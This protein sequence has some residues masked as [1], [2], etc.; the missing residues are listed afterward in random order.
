MCDN[1]SCVRNSN[2][3][4]Y[5]A[6]FLKGVKP[7]HHSDCSTCD[8]FACGSCAFAYTESEVNHFELCPSDERYLPEPYSF[9]HDEKQFNF[10]PFR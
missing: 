9:P 5:Y 2:N 6:L 1:F 10:N 8:D 4:S 7:C 3:F